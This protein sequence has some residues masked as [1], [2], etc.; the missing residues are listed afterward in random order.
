MLVPIQALREIS[1]DSYS[2]F[3]VQPDGSLRM[4]TVTIGLQDYANAEI[5]SGLE[6]G[7]TVS[8]GSVETK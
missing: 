2:V 6:Q 4:V 3:V 8:T 7:A 1:P 5:L